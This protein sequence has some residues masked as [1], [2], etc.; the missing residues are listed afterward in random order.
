MH[1]VFI[2]VWF[3]LP[4]GLANITPLGA[5]K[6]PGLRDFTAP[7]DGG[8]T[9]RGKR[10]LGAH[11]TWRGLLSGILF[12]IITLWLEKELVMHIAW[13]GEATKPLDYAHMP[14]VLLGALFGLGALGGDA[15]KSFFKRRIGIAPGK[16][17]LPFDQIDYIVGS[18]LITSLMVRLTLVQYI[19]ALVIGLVATL[20]GSYIGYHTHFKDS[21]I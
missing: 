2:A 8:K 4:A 10:I 13:L 17:W 14:T 7:I 18:A 20:L 12:A 9:F 3:F 6:F 5:A 1:D 15:L 19:W 16:S 11:K 21:P